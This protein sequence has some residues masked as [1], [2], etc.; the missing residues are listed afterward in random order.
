MISPRL[1][2]LILALTFVVGC[3]GTPTEDEQYQDADR[4]AVYYDKFYSDQAACK[5][6]G[7]AMQIERRGRTRL[8]CGSRSCPPEPGDI[9]R[10]QLRR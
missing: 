7:G 1:T 5:A 3:A 8:E 9:Y 2:A 10:C 4:A 6:R